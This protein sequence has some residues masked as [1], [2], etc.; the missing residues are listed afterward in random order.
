MSKDSFAQSAAYLKQA[1]PLMIKYQIPTTP[2]N[3]HLWYN[4][5][6]GAMPELNN[7]VDHAIK[8]QGTFSSPPVSVSI[9]S[10]WPARTSN[11]W[12]R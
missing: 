7:A 10:I 8:L 6:S 5:V 2:N 1:V 4:Y 9:T 11:R 3:Y 12:R